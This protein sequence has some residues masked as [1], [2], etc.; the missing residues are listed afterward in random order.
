MA[1]ILPVLVYIFLHKEK[2]KMAQ[3][4]I[5]SPEFS[6]PS[7]QKPVWAGRRGE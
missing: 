5:K 1:R 3:I 2:L 7:A 4:D 6:R